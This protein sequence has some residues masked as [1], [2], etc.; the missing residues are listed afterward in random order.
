MRWPDVEALVV[1]HLSTALNVRVTTKLPGNFTMPIVR[2]TRGPGSDDGIS[3]F[4]LCDVE[5]FAATT[6]AMWTL[7]EDAREAM[8]AL[9]NTGLIDT[10]DTATSPTRVSYEQPGVERAVAS[11]RLTAR[12]RALV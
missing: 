2:V 3:D 6:G 12:K 5:V 8:H 10:V 1:A 9:H 4:S 11:Y 7:A